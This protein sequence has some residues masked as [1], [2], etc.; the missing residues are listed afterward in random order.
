MKL[1][2]LLQGVAKNK[3]KKKNLCCT[4]TNET[5]QREMKTKQNK[6]KKKIRKLRISNFH[7]FCKNAIKTKMRKKLVKEETNKQNSVQ[8][9]KM[10][11][12]LQAQD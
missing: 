1:R 7:Y 9:K 10:Q 3:I 12:V 6:T 4:T 11:K 5:M 8:L 2:T